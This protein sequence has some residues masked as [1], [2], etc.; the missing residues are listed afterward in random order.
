M[1]C[2]EFVHYFVKLRISLAVA[3]TNLNGIQFLAQAQ[4]QQRCTV[5]STLR[6]EYVFNQLV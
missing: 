3:S 6:A 1:V 5:A 4:A 2:F